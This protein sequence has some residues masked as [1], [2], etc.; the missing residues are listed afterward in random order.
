MAAARRVKIWNP[1]LIAPGRMGRLMTEFK[2]L[3]ALFSPTTLTNPERQSYIR[4][5]AWA[6]SSLHHSGLH[7]ECP[8]EPR[9]P[10]S[11]TLLTAPSS[12]ASRPWLPGD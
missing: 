11:S 6:W 4:A 7:L 10:S 2:H 8:A 12:V 3:R 9:E 1:N 5:A